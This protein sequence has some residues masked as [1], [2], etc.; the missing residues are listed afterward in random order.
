MSLN[1][2]NP[3]WEYAGYYYTSDSDPFPGTAK[4]RTFAPYSNYQLSQI[5]ENNK[6]IS[7]VLGTVT[8]NDEISGEGDPVVIRDRVAG[9]K[10][11]IERLKEGMNVVVVDALGRVMMRMEA[12]SDV[13][14]FDAPE[15]V[16][17]IRIE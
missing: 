4:V 8:G 6:Q 11:R 17:F 12:D 2:T 15:C 14:E 9:G 10:V 16:Y 5:T 7:F 3:L 13:M 1:V